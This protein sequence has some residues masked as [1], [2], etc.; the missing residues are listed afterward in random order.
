[1]WRAG[2]DADRSGTVNLLDLNLTLSHILG[3]E[4]GGCDML[5]MDANGDGSINVLDIN[6]ILQII[7]DADGEGAAQRKRDSGVIR[8]INTKVI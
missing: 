5:Q 3:N 7:L 4:V 6:A 1:M 2:S 8:I